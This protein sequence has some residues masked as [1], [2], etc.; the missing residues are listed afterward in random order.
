MTPSLSN[1]WIAVGSSGADTIEYS[2]DGSN[3][4]GVT[5]GGF[6]G[7]GWGVA[8]NGSLWVAV[9]DDTGAPIKYSSDGQTWTNIEPP[10]Y[11]IGYSVAWNGSFWVT[12]GYEGSGD[13]IWKSVDGINWIGG[14][15]NAFPTQAYGVAWNGLMWVAAGADNTPGGTIKYSYDGDTWYNLSSGLGFSGYSGFG[16]AWNGYMWVAVGDDPTTNNTI[17]YS[18]DG[19]NW[20][21]C[22]SGGFD[23]YGSGY[24][25]G[26][27][28]NGKMWVAV[29]GAA[30]QTDRIKYSYDGKNWLNS[31]TV[32]GSFTYGAR[33][34][35]NGSLWIVTGASGYAPSV[36][37]STDG[38]NWFESVTGGFSGDGQGVA[39]SANLTP[40][41]SQENFEIKPQNIPN[42][43]TTKNQLFMTSTTMVL[44]NTLYIDQ[45]NKVGI[46]T[47]DIKYP[48]DVVGTA[49]F[50]SPIIANQAA[51]FKKS[52]DV[53]GTLTNRIKLVVST[54]GPDVMYI[55]D[56]D[57]STRFIVDGSNSPQDVQL[58]D[59]AA[60]GAGWN[61][62]MSN[63]LT[64]SMS[65]NVYDVILSLITTIIPGSN[66]NIV[67]DGSYWYLI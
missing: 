2:T 16:V 4:S 62:G 46:N 54:L 64:G 45:S 26:V 32:S 31:T 17:Q 51:E 58:P 14:A 3:W 34:A 44:N 8:W 53:R 35:W 30:T 56:T 25:F 61:I 15:T 23:N 66:A 47:P 10:A 12:V 57:I 63:L 24:G 7:M 60:A 28:W 40:S 52:V 38:M 50:Q 36:Q 20:F 6:S 41:F 59:T 37:Y 43:L 42:Y 18:Y 19:M 67:T 55:N 13:T 11:T 49:R 29:G 48:L 1:I 9:G 22:D 33:V 21:A 39:F 27:A 5:S 65:I